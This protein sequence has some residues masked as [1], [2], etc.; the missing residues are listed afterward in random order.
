MSAN[1]P[2]EERALAYLRQHPDGSSASTVGQVVWPDRKTSKCASHG[3]GDYAAQM[4]LG[5]MRRRGLVDRLPG[6]GSTRWVA[7]SCEGKR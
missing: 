4:L 2:A 7:C 5:R 6:S 3:G 1:H